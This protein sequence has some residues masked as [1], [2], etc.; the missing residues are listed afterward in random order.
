MDNED[1]VRKAARN[2][3]FAMFRLAVVEAIREREERR[4]GYRPG[5]SNAPG[6][7]SELEAFAG[8][9]VVRRIK[10]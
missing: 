4:G 10:S 1:F 2:I 8:E 6:N 9:E 5:D 7:W 3:A